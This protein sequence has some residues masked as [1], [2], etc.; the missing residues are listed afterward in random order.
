MARGNLCAYA[1]GIPS[2][3]GVDVLDSSRRVY[4]VDV[5]AK[6]GKVTVKGNVDAKA[7]IHR[8][9]KSGKVAE[10]WPEIGRP[11]AGANPSETYPPRADMRMKKDWWSSLSDEHEKGLIIEE[12]T[13]AGEKSSARM[14][15]LG[16]A[17]ASRLPA[18]KAMPS[19]NKLE[20][21]SNAVE[22]A[23][24]RIKIHDDVFS[25]TADELQRCRR[26]IKI[27]KNRISKHDGEIAEWDRRWKEMAFKMHDGDAP[28]NDPP[29]A[30]NS[31]WAERFRAPTKLGLVE[32]RLEDLIG[33]GGEAT[34][35]GMEMVAAAEECA[36][37]S[38]ESAKSAANSCATAKHMWEI[39]QMLIRRI[40]MLK[41]SVE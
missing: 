10:L 1:N 4:T 41:A 14:T 5:D 24:Q 37:S 18:Q 20:I 23:V 19:E 39:W 32:E 6:S 35:A 12:E 2:A 38:A 30:G 17:F 33:V 22:D 9:Y 36:L 8:L 28:A 40:E 15:N 34:K 25:G 7:L 13:A 31:C 3:P 27:A 11:A 21:L 29:P 26:A 16:A